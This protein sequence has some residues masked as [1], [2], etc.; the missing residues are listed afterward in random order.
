VILA[1]EAAVEQVILKELKQIFG[2]QAVEWVC[3]EFGVLDELHGGFRG[4][5]KPVA[6][7]QLLRT[8]DYGQRKR[9]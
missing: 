4:T 2:A 7:C 9:L 8:T 1:V 5:K 6:R 3:D